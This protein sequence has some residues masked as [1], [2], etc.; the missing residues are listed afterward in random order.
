MKRFTV[1][2]TVEPK[3]R[4]WWRTGGFGVYPILETR[5]EFLAHL[6]GGL[7]PTGSVA[8]H[9]DSHPKVDAEVIP[10]QC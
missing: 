4:N 3:S 9:I 1:F 2:R 8:M 5:S 7:L 6:I 10:F